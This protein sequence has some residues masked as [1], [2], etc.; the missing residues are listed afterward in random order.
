[1]LYKMNKDNMS[2]D[3][4][5]FYSLQDLGKLEKD[6]E[7]IMVQ[8]IKELFLDNTQIM[9]VFQETAWQEEPDICAL[10]KDGNLILFE[11]KRH[12]V[13]ASTTM[14]I[15]RYVEIFGQKTYKELNKYYQKF[16]KINSDLAEDHKIAFELKNKLKPSEFNQNQK[17]IIVGNSMD[18]KLIESID[19]WSSQG[20]DIEFIPY[21]IYKIEEEYYF[22]FFSKPHD[23]H[24]NPRE[25]KAVL[26]D[27]NKSYDESEDGLF[28]MLSEGKISSYGN[29]KR[30]VNYLNK[31]DIVLYYRK[32]YGV[33]GAGIVTSE[34]SIEKGNERYKNVKIL[35]RIPDNKLELDKLECISASELKETLNKD[36]YFPSTIKTPYLT[37][38][39]GEILINILNN[40]TV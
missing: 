35:T 20:I 11:L 9:T 31:D 34:S 3:K 13:N 10:D 7:N 14:Q 38:Q 25:R 2:L 23:F 39:E 16:M 21:R 18:L 27:T 26:F 40:A 32:G 24:L 28:S 29:A 17:L 1:M 30:F 15:L 33:I 19:F 5:N 6:L 12:N 4:L 8:N 22:E 36:F 37:Y